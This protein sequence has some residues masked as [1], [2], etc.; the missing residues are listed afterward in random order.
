MYLVTMFEHAMGEQYAFRTV[1]LMIKLIVRCSSSINYTITILIAN[2]EVTLNNPTK[3]FLN[4][5]QMVPTKFDSQ[6][7]ILMKRIRGIFS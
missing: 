3:L 6:S 5:A 7:Y 1:A 2:G 4:N